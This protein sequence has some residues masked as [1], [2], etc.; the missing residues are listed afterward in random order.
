MT[1]LRQK[2]IAG[3]RDSAYYL[4]FL[5]FALMQIVTISFS[6]DYFRTPAQTIDGE[7]TSAAVS[8]LGMYLGLYAFVLVLFSVYAI[9]GALRAFVQ[10]VFSVA[11]PSQHSATVDVELSKLVD[12]SNAKS[13]DSLICQ[14]SSQ[15]V[16]RRDRNLQ[17]EP[18][19]RNM[20]Y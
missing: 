11:I 3:L 19:V 5:G 18:C 16:C 17:S 15:L 10:R 7:T 12:I 8:P 4:A 13:I 9:F 1:S 14:L 6:F 20:G 2:T